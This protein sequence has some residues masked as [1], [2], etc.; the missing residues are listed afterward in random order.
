MDGEPDGQC[1]TRPM[2]ADFP[3]M[4]VLLGH[5]VVED[6]YGTSWRV[7]KRWMRQTLGE[8]EL[9]GLRR[10]YLRKVAAAKGLPMAVGC[11]PGR[12]IGG[13]G[14]L[15]AGD[16]ALE[17]MPIRRVRRPYRD[18][19]WVRFPDGRPKPCPEE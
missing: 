5:K 15:Q 17:W 3:E 11:K 7:V 19:V 2:P 16:P 6:Y 4:F 13:I 18:E 14:E 12:R 10:G 1:H 9:I 8:A